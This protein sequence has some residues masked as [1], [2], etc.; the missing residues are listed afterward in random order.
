MGSRSDTTKLKTIDYHFCTRAGSS[1]CAP[2][3]AAAT[4]RRR[5]RPETGH[6]TPDWKIH[7]SV[8]MQDM[9]VSSHVWIAT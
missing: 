8:E 6:L 4:G 1:A 9:A 7:F 2:S 5:T 3:E